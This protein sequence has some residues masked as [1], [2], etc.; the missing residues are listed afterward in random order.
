MHEWLLN[1]PLIKGHPLGI[2]VMEH[3]GVVTSVHNLGIIPQVNEK[4]PDFSVRTGDRITA[5]NGDVG[6][7]CRLLKKAIQL[8]GE[9]VQLRFFRP[10]SLCVAVELNGEDLGLV[11]ETSSGTITAIREGSLATRCSEPSFEVGDRIVKVNG[12]EP[13]EDDSIM[14]WL[15][16]AIAG[17][18][19]PLELELVRGSVP[20]DLYRDFVGSRGIRGSASSREQHVPRPESGSSTDWFS[21]SAKREADAEAR[22]TRDG[23]VL[24]AQSGPRRL[25]VPE[26]RNIDQATA[27]PRRDRSP[28]PALNSRSVSATRRSGLGM[29]LFAKL[30]KTCFP[31]GERMRALRSRASS[32]ASEIT[33]DSP[34]GRMYSNR[35]KEADVA[36]FLPALASRSSSKD[37]VLTEP[38]VAPVGPRLSSKQSVSQSR[39]SS[40]E[41]V[42]LLPIPSLKR[43]DARAF[44][45][46]DDH[47]GCD[48]RCA[49]NAAAAC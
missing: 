16:L 32:T 8:G 26:L 36:P 7:A 47:V 6:D 9:V 27:N 48:P 44:R 35:D 4:H 49:L 28:L 21:P 15:R 46:L 22:G 41:P 43:H 2:S 39:S 5:V 13:G 24:N 37:S 17:G 3:T 31:H 25:S 1:I 42:L 23:R 34:C 11:V 10:F 20:Q 19:S 18:V 33:A 29:P 14:P 40:K 30:S 38:V 12:R 45:N